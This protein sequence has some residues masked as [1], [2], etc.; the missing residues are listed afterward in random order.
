MDLDLTPVTS[1]DVPALTALMRDAFDDSTRRHTDRERGGPPG[2][3]DGTMLTQYAVG[4]AAARQVREGGEPVAVLVTFRQDE[5]RAHLGCLAVAVGH[6]RRGIGRR[7]LADLR[8]RTPEVTTWTLETPE[9]E[10]TNHRFYESC[11]F[12]QVGAVP[13]DPATGEPAL[14]RYRWDAADPA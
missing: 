6:Q 12:V 7:L 10:T 5:R 3:D 2:Y 4:N 8:A 13:A 11:G 14:R 1:D 9:H